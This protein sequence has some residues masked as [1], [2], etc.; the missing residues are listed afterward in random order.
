MAATTQNT[1]SHY[2]MRSYNELRTGDRVVGLGDIVRVRKFRFHVSCA[3]ESYDGEHMSWHE[4]DGLVEC[5]N[6]ATV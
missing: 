4:F 3:I 6:D 5:V 1:N 2:I